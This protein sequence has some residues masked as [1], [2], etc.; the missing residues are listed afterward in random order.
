MLVCSETYTESASAVPDVIARVMIY[1]VCHGE[2]DSVEEHI[3]AK[4]LISLAR[5]DHNSVILTLPIG[6]DN[7]VPVAEVEV[8]VVVIRTGSVLRACDLSC[9]GFGNGTVAGK[10][11]S[12]GVECR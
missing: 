9:D 3:T 1:P 6:K 12:V 8:Q 10:D 5:H 2:R 11:D 4:V 7:H